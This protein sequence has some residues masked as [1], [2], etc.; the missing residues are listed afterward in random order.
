MSDDGWDRSDDR[1]DYRSEDRSEDNK[2]P[3]VSP[4][5]TEEELRRRVTAREISAG[6]PPPRSSAFLFSGAD[7]SVISVPQELLLEI[8]ESFAMFSDGNLM[9]VQ[10]VP[11]ALRSMGVDVAYKD[12]GA[13]VQRFE[14]D[15]RDHID[16][17]QWTAAVVERLAK[18]YDRREQFRALLQDADDKGTGQVTVKHVRHLLNTFEP[19]SMTAIDADEMVATTEH[20]GLI[21]VNE[22]MD[23]MLSPAKVTRYS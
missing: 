8:Q 11:D 16:N 5:E 19:S 21:N 15:G 6:R 18:D 7:G 14:V 10:Q 12:V 17:N 22:F 2:S 1:S 23:T 13:V 4:Q 9:S 20:A 3:Q